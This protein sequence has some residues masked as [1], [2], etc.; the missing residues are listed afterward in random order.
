MFAMYLF[1][2]EVE[3]ASLNISAG[4]TDIIHHWITFLEILFGKI[5]LTF[6]GGSVSYLLGTEVETLLLSQILFTS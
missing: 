6:N 4:T 3:L 2:T 5:D 1:G